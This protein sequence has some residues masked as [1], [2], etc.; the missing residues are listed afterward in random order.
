MGL[1]THQ[2]MYALELETDFKTAFNALRYAASRI[3]RVLKSDDVY[4]TV[5]FD[6]PL[7]FS[8]MPFQFN[9]RIK[10]ND[11][12]SDDETITITLYGETYGAGLTYQKAADVKFA[13]FRQN[14][15][16]FL[17]SHDDLEKSFI[18]DSCDTIND[19]NSSLSDKPSTSVKFTP[20]KSVGFYLQLNT[21]QNKW[22][23]PFTLNRRIYDY[24][25]LVS[26]ELIEDGETITSGGLGRSIAGHV[27]VPIVGGIIGGVTAK[28]KTKPLCSSLLI[29]ITVNDINESTRF[30]KF[31]EKATKKSSLTYK[32]AFQNAQECLSIFELI[33]KYNEEQETKANAVKTQIA[34]ITPSSPV[35]NGKIN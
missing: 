15:E 30:I 12:E 23:L 5:Y 7:S 20:N 4:G 9:A 31:I 28:R 24:S 26:Y 18:E 1:I 10:E 3:G 33:N 13:D 35:V 29:R 17:D 14:I 22:R 8:A 34:S 32:T 21:Y 19:T 25:E 2:V 27:L 16:Y 6:T 11:D